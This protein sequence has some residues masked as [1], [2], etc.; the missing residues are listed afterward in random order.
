MLGE[1]GGKEKRNCIGE[2]AA[3]TKR[4]A[5]GSR[6]R[7]GTHLLGL[8]WQWRMAGLPLFSGV[9]GCRLL[10][11]RASLPSPKDGAVHLKG[12]NCREK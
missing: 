5:D 7:Y 4:A 6:L 8:I 11:A 12:A 1:G 3:I 2:L 10:R 9:Q